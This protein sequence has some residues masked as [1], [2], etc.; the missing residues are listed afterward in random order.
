MVGGEFTSAIRG[1]LQGLHQTMRR[2]ISPTE[3]RIPREGFTNAKVR[4]WHAPS[5]DV[6]ARTFLGENYILA[7]WYNNFD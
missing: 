5:P 7:H 3:I 6:K 4:L 2:R 1:Q